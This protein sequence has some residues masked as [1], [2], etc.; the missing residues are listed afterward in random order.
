MSTILGLPANLPPDAK[1]IEIAKKKAE[2]VQE[3][4]DVAS[5]EL[6][7]TN[8]VLESDLSASQKEGDVGKALEQN[9]ATEERINQAADELAEVSE[10]L[11]EEVA[12]RHRLE[13]E[14]ARRAAS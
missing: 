9:Q 4:I 3:Q 5:A 12:Q 10:Q 8:T 7:L 14:L 11:E 2:D 1:P 13:Q 6:H